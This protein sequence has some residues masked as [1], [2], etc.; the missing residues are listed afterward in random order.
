MSGIASK[1]KPTVTPNP[2]ATKTAAKT[3]A[4]TTKKIAQPKEVSPVADKDEPTKLEPYV[5]ELK[6]KSNGMTRK[7][8]CTIPKGASAIVSFEVMVPPSS[9]C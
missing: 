4:K 6:T 5:A 9:V 7:I 3:A 2:K 1:P 8:K